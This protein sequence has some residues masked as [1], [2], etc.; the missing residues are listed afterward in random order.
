MWL[1]TAREHV[2]RRTVWWWHMAAVVGA[3]LEVDYA[4]RGSMVGSHWLQWQNWNTAHIGEWHL[5][6][7]KGE[8]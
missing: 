8:G 2:P 7:V 4:W 1:V 6:I 5:G 3:I